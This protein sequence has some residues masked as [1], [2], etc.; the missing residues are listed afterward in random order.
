MIKGCQRKVIVVKGDEESMF[1]CAYFVLKNDK[2]HDNP[3][4]GDMIA[5]ADKIIRQSCRINDKKCNENSEKKPKEY[6]KIA[7]PFSVGALVG[8]LLGLLW[9]LL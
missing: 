5:E 7:I 3:S 8:A 6:K 4:E 9:L 1:E 2:N